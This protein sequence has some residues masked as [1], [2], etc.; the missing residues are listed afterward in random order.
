MDEK[1][2]L[3]ETQDKIMSI[4]NVLDFEKT[5]NC[6]NQYLNEFLN[7]IKEIHTN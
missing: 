4:N 6:M 5:R 2:V 7:F 3:K 1:E